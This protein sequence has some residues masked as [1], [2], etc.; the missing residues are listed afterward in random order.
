MDTQLYEHVCYSVSE[1]PMTTHEYN[2]LSIE[3][4]ADSRGTFHQVL[5][6]LH[7]HTSMSSRPTVSTLLLL[8]LFHK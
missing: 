2:I 7:G 4:V 1:D 8:R 6:S 3:S 5:L